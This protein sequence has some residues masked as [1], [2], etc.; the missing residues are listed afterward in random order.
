[1]PLHFKSARA[2]TRRALSIGCAVWLLAGP[3]CADPPASC[4][5]DGLAPPRV[6]VERF[7]RADCLSCWTGNHL[8]A[9]PPGAVILDWVLPAEAGDDAPMAAVARREG[10]ER[11][12]ALRLNLPAGRPLEWQSRSKRVGRGRLRVQH[13]PV[14]GDFVGASLTFHARDDARGPFTGWLALAEWL[15]KDTEGSPVARVL[16]RNLLTE[17]I[18]PRPEKNWA[19]LWRPMNIPEGA[20]AERLGVVGWVTDARGGLVALAQAHCSGH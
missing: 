6:L 5:N 2:P 1:M 17:P 8:A 10:L 4:S 9:P 16:V 7:L 12:E 20:R 19:Q 11:Q 13:G 14:V 3:V 15:P 18:G